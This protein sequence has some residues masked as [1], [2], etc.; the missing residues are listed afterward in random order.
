MLECLFQSTYSARSGSNHFFFKAN[1]VLSLFLKVINHS[2][3]WSPVNLKHHLSCTHH[4]VLECVASMS[5]TSATARASLIEDAVPNPSR[6]LWLLAQYQ[7]HGHYSVSI[8]QLNEGNK[9][10]AHLDTLFFVLSTF[11]PTGF[12]LLNSDVLP[13]G[14][15]RHQS[16]CMERGQVRCFQQELGNTDCHLSIFINC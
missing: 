11:F 9:Q 13:H 16:A 3:L 2:F 8:C 10:P 1:T 6:Y 7:V 4:S 12:T 14:G 15:L 5:A